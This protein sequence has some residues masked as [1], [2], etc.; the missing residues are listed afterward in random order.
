ME[1][2]AQSAGSA[3]IFARLPVRVA[4]QHFPEVIGMVL[5]YLRP[6]EIWA[7]E[8]EFGLDDS[9]AH[10]VRDYPVETL[11]LVSACVRKDQGHAIYH[12]ERTLLLINGARPDLEQ[13]PRMRALR[14]L[15]VNDN[16]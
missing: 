10:L 15:V 8:L 1:P 16:R 4:P 2:A 13:D 3:K 12:L 14:L 6:F 11:A 7:V 5:P 9:S